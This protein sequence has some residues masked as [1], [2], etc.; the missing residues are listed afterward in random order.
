MASAAV[1]NAAL[2]DLGDKTLV[3]DTFMTARAADELAGESTRLTGRAPYLVVNSHWHSD[4][5]G[6]NNVFADAAIIGTARMRELIAEDVPASRAAFEEAAASLQKSAEEA[7][8][9][10][11]TAEDR[12]AASGLSALANALLAD[13]IGHQRALPGVLIDERLDIHGRERSVS[14]RTY[15][16]GHT[17]SDIFV[18]L[19]DDEVLIT[20]DL[21]WTGVHPKTSDGFPGAWVRVLDRIAG[22]NFGKVL[23]GH[24]PPGVLRAVDAMVGDIRNGDLRVEDAEPPGGTEDWRDPVRFRAG[25]AH[26]AAR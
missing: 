9:K 7:A 2:I 19:P 24:G 11:R 14:I 15:G 21:V 4:H 20:G 23:S 8:G 13:P 1:S 3:V 5:V 12:S 10:A 6:G 17:E 25:L 26:L 18:H 16:R 22:L